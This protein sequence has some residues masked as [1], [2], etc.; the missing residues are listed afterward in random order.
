LAFV[1]EVESVVD[2]DLVDEGP[3]F[4]DDDDESVEA[5]PSPSFTPLP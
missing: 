3:L 1:L 5:P 2:E 4:V